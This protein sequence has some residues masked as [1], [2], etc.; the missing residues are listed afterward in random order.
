MRFAFAFKGRNLAKIG[1]A[2]VSTV[3]QETALQTVALEDAGCD[4]I[5]T[6]HGVSGAVAERPQ[7][8]AMLDHLRPG[9]EVVVWKLDRLGRNTRNLLELVEDMSSRGVAFRSVTE[10]ITTGGAMG[11]A[12]LTIMGAFAELE[13]AQLIERTKAGLAIAKEHGRRGGRPRVV[14]TPGIRRAR[15]LHSQG[16][17][18]SDIGKILG[19]SRATIYRYLQEQVR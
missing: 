3:D 14:D 10:G 1:Y 4:R 12:M 8:T 11:K 19:V 6:D 2:R 5:F 13:R 15:Q 9:D 18:A 7:L 16:L 17:S